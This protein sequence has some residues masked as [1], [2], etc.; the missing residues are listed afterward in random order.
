MNLSKSKKFLVTVKLVFSLLVLSIAQQVSANEYAVVNFETSE[1][2]MYRITYEQLVERG[3][4]LRGLRHRYFSLTDGKSSVA[5]RTVG[6]QGRS[7]QRNKFGPGS[8]IEFYAESADSLYSKSK[9]YTLEYGNW[10]NWNKIRNAPRNT[11][12]KKNRKVSN[13]IIS[14]LVVEEDNYYDFLSPSKTDPW[15]FGQMFASAAG[16]TNGTKVNFS[17]PGLVGDSANIDIEVYG[18]V[19]IQSDE[20]DHHFV[21]KLNGAEIGDQ[22]FDGNAKSVLSI[23]QV[24]VSSNNEFQLAIRGIASTPFDLIGLN[25]LTISYN[26]HA[27][28]INGYLE[29]QLDTNQQTVVS[30]VIPKSQ[31]NGY[32]KDHNGRMH[33][34]RLKRLSVDTVGFRAFGKPASYILVQADG[35]KTPEVRVINDQQE[36]SSGL[37]EYL[38]LSHKQFIGDELEELVKI[39]EQQYAVKVVDVE[40]VYGQYG[41]HVPSDD[42]IKKYVAHAAQNMGTKFVLLVGADTYDYKNIQGSN[43]KSFVPTTY[44]STPSDILT[45]QQTPSDAAYGDTNNDGVPELPVGRLS[46]RTNAELVDVIDKIKAYRQRDGYA[47]RIVLAADKDDLGNGVSFR[48]MIDKVTEVLPNDWRYSVRSDFRVIP[49][50]DGDQVAHDKLIKAMNAGVSVVSYIGHSAQRV[51]SRATPPLFRA[52]DIS[53]LVNFGKPTVVTQWGCWNTYFVDPSGNNMADLLL[54]GG[55]NGA[56]AVMGAST[57]T[58]A[59]A[60]SKLS[61]E[62]SKRMYIPGMTIGEAV[63]AAKKAMSVNGNVQDLS[64]V[65]LGWQIIGDPAIQVAR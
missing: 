49:D 61:V 3:V 53:E 29:G 21:A 26:R 37:A 2:G 34:L 24:A 63:I 16:D 12:F 19:D 62:L 42:A 13:T 60:E 43:S 27:E 15:H 32:R 14:T 48:K 33:R 41:N 5:I 11:V 28:L 38:I 46:V 10:Q 23:P 4:D 8:Y 7:S 52:N 54:V 44:V 50:V 47:G 36:I 65:L 9:I 17:L 1:A 59:E 22:Q 20:N 56:V 40:Q 55:K 39:R 31:I 30:G 58:S 35:Y 25:K 57:L 6:Q 64:D 18:I 51:W 45:I